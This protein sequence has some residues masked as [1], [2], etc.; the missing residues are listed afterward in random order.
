MYRFWGRGRSWGVRAGLACMLVGCRPP[1]P[2][3]MS[4][5]NRIGVCTTDYRQVQ[6]M[7]GA[8]QRV[9][10]TG[11]LVLWTYENPAGKGALLVA[12]SNDIVVDYAFNA[13]GLVELADRCR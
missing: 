3:T 5:V 12:F 13:P 8:P 1:P 6:Q 7:F 10:R 2:I 9:G 4:E 11:S